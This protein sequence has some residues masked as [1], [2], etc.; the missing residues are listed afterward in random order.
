M[1]AMQRGIPLLF[2]LGYRGSSV[3]QRLA[4]SRRFWGAAGERGRAGVLRGTAE[5]ITVTV[6]PLPPVRCITAMCTPTDAGAY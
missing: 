6:A 3:R 5:P 2:F 4:R 1:K